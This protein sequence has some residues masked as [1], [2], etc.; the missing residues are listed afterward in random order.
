M[1]ITIIIVNYNTCELTRNCLKSIIAETK[2]IQFEIIVS[3]NGSTDQSIEMIKTE[4]PQ[5]ILLENKKNLGFGAA[6]NRALEIA[7]GK[8]I[9]F[10]NSDT[11]LMFDPRIGSS[12]NLIHQKLSGCG[13]VW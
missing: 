1:D 2:D 12:N 3:D 10:L 9:I 4:F 5:V 8:Y 13:A 7:K 6:N 11:I